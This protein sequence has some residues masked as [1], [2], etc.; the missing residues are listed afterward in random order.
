MKKYYNIAMKNLKIG[1]IELEGNV[2]LAPMAGFTS[3]PFRRQ[4]REMGASL[5][6]TEMVSAK[7]CLFGNEKT[8]EILDTHECEVP[9]A[10]QIFGSDPDVIAEAIKLPIFD[11]FD[12]ID[13][14]MGCPAPKIV[15]N[16]EGSALLKDMDLA[17]KIIKSAVEAAF[18]RPVTV[19]FRIGYTKDNIVA[20][21]F[22]KMCENAGASAITIHGRTTEQGYSGRAD[23]GIIADCKKA[24]NIPVIANGDCNSKE[25]F[26]RII[27]ETGADGVMIGRGALGNPQIFSEIKG[28]KNQKSRKEIV[29][30]YLEYMKEYFPEKRALLES[31]A[32]IMF[33][34]KGLAGSTKVKT[35][36]MKASNFDEIFCIIND[37][38]NK[39]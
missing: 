34:L 36:I 4:A 17:K 7:A 39:F 19:K 14:N 2:L 6:T 38:F 30:C 5:A 8:F 25:D 32:H 1:N 16:G 3:L 24:V 15:S 13:I 35:E 27:D 33:F 37:F 11:K 21:E 28:I 18:P 22:A 9:C 10:C 26:E 31:R 20:V 12:I 23:M 29:T